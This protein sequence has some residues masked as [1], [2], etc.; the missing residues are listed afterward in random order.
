MKLETPL[1]LAAID[2]RTLEADALPAALD[3]TTDSRAIRAGQAFLALRGER[4][5]GH[6]YVAA[7]YD[8]G[9]ACCIVSDASRVPAGRPAIVVGDTLR[10]YLALAK[11]ARTRIASK[12]IAISGSAGKTSTKSFLLQLMDAAGVRATATPENENNEIGVAKFF[13]GLEESD[14]RV[15]IVEMGARKYR[16]LDVLVDVARPEIAILTNIGEAHLEIMGSRERLAD[17]KWGLFSSGARAVLNLGDATSRARVGTLPLPPIW[18]GAGNVVPPTG[19]PG[20]VI[21]NPKTLVVHDGTAR[22]TYAIDAQVPGEH[23][24]ANVAAALA[25]AIALGTPPAALAGHVAALVMPHGRYQR[26]ALERDIVLIYDAYNANM[27]GTLATLATFAHEPAQ[28]RIA[29]LGSMAELGAE[30]AS[31][32]RRVGE[33][34]HAVCGILLAGGDH[35]ADL[36]RGALDAGFDP[37]AVV[38]YADNAEAVAWLRAHLRSGDAVL[39]KGSRR[40]QMEE[41][42]AGL[43]AGVAS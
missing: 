41:I 12:V 4:F 34:V 31:M 36:E 21:T 23:N 13:L 29:V 8:A 14:T 7:A 42:V 6:D 27:S 9:A 38:R 25:G 37:S 19:E 11:L 35:A 32:H 5:D 33:A 20:V 39:I 22:Q 17:T 43:E 3:I 26:V 30:A 28:R 18:F 16:D 15:A 40:Y 1:A 10:A 2:G 24:R